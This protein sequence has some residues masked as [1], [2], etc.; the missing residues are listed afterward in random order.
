MDRPNGDGLF[1][2][3]ELGPIVQ[4]FGGP[5]SSIAPSLE[6][7]YADEFDLGAQ[8]HPLRALDLSISFFRRDDKHRLAA[9]N[10]GVP[11]SDFSP[12]TILDPGSDGIPGT[13]DDQ[14]LTVYQQNSAS[15]GQDH[16]VLINPPDLRTLNKGAQVEIRTTWR[17]LLLDASFVAEESL[18][19][20]NPGD[21]ASRAIP[22]WLARFTW[23]PTRS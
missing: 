8:I 6:R 22:E 17:N 10:T 3:G 7:P 21:A 9:V 11:P 2:P 19:P 4:R 20:T 15:F 13:F 14:S 5:Y 23:T 16:Y 1:E 12:V 18:G